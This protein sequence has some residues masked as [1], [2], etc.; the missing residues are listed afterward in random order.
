MRGPFE[1]RTVTVSHSK[2]IQVV[3][4]AGRVQ[5]ETPETPQI[6]TSLRALVAYQ[7]RVHEV[8]VEA[9]KAIH[10]IGTLLVEKPPDE[11]GRRAGEGAIELARDLG[12]ALR[13]EAKSEANR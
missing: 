11:D 8:A 10:A 13:G 9:G 1:I 2:M 5:L 6:R 12:A 7:N 4:R 3:D